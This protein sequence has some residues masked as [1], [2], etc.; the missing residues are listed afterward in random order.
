MQ[1]LLILTQTP[2]VSSPQLCEQPSKLYIN[3]WPLLLQ[4]SLTAT[5]KLSGQVS[6]ISVVAIGGCRLLILR[7]FSHL[8]SS[9]A[10]KAYFT[11]GQAIALVS[12]RGD[13][14][15]PAPNWFS[16]GLVHMWAGGRAP[17][18]CRRKKRVNPFRRPSRG[19]HTMDVRPYCL[20]TRSTVSTPPRCELGLNACKTHRPAVA[21]QIPGYSLGLVHTSSAFEELDFTAQEKSKHSKNAPQQKALI[22]EIQIKAC[23]RKLRKKTQ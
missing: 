2:P 11:T 23:S 5:C 9:E 3:I 7:V 17:A 12:P 4:Q 18:A 22:S 1:L 21:R 13:R 14:P 6:V 15:Q 20:Y 8:G 10:L 16:T 19:S